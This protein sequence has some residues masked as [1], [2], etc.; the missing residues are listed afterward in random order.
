MK[1]RS[2]PKGLTP[3]VAGLAALAAMTT[4]AHADIAVRFDEG[5]PKDRFTFQNV[6]SCPIGNSELTL[7]I[8]GSKSGL[9]F[10]TTG[11]GAGVEV[12]QPLEIVSGSASLSSFTSARD[13]DK[14]ITFSILELQPGDSIAF[15][16]DVDDTSGNREITVSGSEIEGAI[17]RHDQNGKTSTAIISSDARALLKTD[18]C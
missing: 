1:K 8:S 9:I 10:D 16:I 15:T 5:A 17:V 3:L 4:V 12:F 14:Q 18:T 11:N 6:G 7:D 2:H 13:G